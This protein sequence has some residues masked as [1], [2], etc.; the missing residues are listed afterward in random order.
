[1]LTKY[2]F[3][4]VDLI[5]YKKVVAGTR[6]L[7][8]RKKKEAFRSFVDTLNIASNPSYV[9]DKCKIFNNKWV[10]P[11]STVLNE[12]VVT[13]KMEEALGEFFPPWVPSDPDIIP[14]T[15]D[16][17][18]FDAPFSWEEFGAALKSRKLNS[19]P[20]MDGLSYRTLM[21]IPYRFK[22]LLLDFFNEMYCKG[23]FPEEWKETYVQ[24]IKKSDKNSL[25]P[26]A[27]SSCVC[28]L[29]ETMLK[30]RL[31]L[32]VERYNLGPDSQSGFRKG[33]STI[34]LTI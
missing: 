31:D 5:E 10:K 24:F 28:K 11:N 3:S 33:R 19:A 13:K 22:L 14:I 1:M 21:N 7:F 12:N 23:W 34:I 27:L 4:L 25:R 9:W 6:Q 15:E 18:F 32:W 8:K 20:G 2:S 17:E 29:F 30:F 26:I 16:N